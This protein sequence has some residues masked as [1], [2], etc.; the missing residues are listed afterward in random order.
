MNNYSKEEIELTVKMIE[1]NAFGLPETSLPER[2][3]RL[4]D[5]DADTI[6]Q[7]EEKIKRLS[8]LLSKA[9][10]HIE[11]NTLVICGNIMETDIADEIGITQ[12]EYDEIMG[13]E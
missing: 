8:E 2:L 9:I 5:E 4:F 6:M 12:E 11:D 3:Q 7:Q 13:N 1:D 10:A